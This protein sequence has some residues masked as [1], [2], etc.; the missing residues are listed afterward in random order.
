MHFCHLPIKYFPQ[1]CYVHFYSEEQDG[2]M[3][4][5]FTNSCI[6]K[7]EHLLG[8]G[9]RA[10]TSSHDQMVHNDTAILYHRINLC[11]LVRAAIL[12]SP[13]LLWEKHLTICYL[14]PQ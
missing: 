6:Q 3:M 9:T 7:G 12:R 5:I 13:L 10:F 4:M 2:G 8:R 1:V 11:W 14:L